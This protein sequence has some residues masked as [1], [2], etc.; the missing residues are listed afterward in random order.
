MKKINP[1]LSSSRQSILTLKIVSGLI[2]TKVLRKPDIQF[3]IYLESYYEGLL[4][5][6]SKRKWR[7]LPLYKQQNMSILSAQNETDDSS[8]SWYLIR[9]P[10]VF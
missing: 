5:F 3:E 10:A 9:A 7:H 4:R 6:G 8:F 2:V 1:F